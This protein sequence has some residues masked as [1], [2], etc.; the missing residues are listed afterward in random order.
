M[1]GAGVPPDV[2]QFC[3]HFVP[4]E[5][6]RFQGAGGL[7]PEPDHLPCRPSERQYV[8]AI[9]HFASH[10]TTVLKKPKGPVKEK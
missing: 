9:D 7:Q 5:A 8:I 3:E 6:A 1:R 2:L 4:G 10:L